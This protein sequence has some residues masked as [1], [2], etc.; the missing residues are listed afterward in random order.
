MVILVDSHHLKE[1][2]EHLETT[3]LILGQ[4]LV[5]EEEVAEQEVQ[6]TLDLLKQDLEVVEQ[7]LQ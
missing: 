3:Q 2:M 7:H 6:V 5:P 1:I 4:H